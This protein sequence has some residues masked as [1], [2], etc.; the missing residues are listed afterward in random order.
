VSS[1]TFLDPFNA[2]SLSFREVA[3]TFVPSPKFS[4]L[5]GRWN[6][7]LIGPR[8]SGK[9]TLMKMLTVEALRTYEGPLAAS[10]RDI[11]TYTGIY[12]P[13]DIAWKEMV[14]ALCSPLDESVAMLVS[15]AAFLTNV[16]QS[17]V[18]AMQTR[19][20]VSDP[21]VSYP[22]FRKAQ[23][24][25]GKLEET[26]VDIAQLWHL[27][28][29]SIS[30]QGLANALA[31]RLSDI[32]Q[33]ANVFAMTERVSVQDVMK[34]MPY[35]GLSV[36]QAVSSAVQFFDQAINEPDGQWV[37]LLDE[38]E[39]A[40][41]QLQQSV[42]ASLRASPPKLL[43]K[44][45]LSPCGPH[46]MHRE[47]AATP[48]TLHND[49]RQVHLWYVDREHAEG[50]CAHIF[51]SLK[52]RWPDVMPNAS[53]EKVFG[54]TGYAIV[55]ETGESVE[56]GSYGRG[57]FWRR[58]FQQ[59]AQKDRT[60]SDFLIE[61][62]I[63]ADELDPS[64]SAPNGNTIRKIAPVVA[65]RNAYKGK[66]EGQKRGRRPFRSAYSGWAAICAISEGNPRWFI[67]LINSLAPCL[68]AT[69]TLPISVT[70]QQNKL[71]DLSE[72]FAEILRS[73]ATSQLRGLDTDA[74]VYDVLA[75]IGEYF[76]KRLVLDRFVEDP[77]MS[78][79]V[80]DDVDA[81]TEN[82]LRIAMNHGALVCYENPDS[83]GGYASLRGKRFR[84]AYLLAPA[85]K[86]PLRKSKAV[87][88][89]KALAMRETPRAP[90]QTGLLWE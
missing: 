87:N 44:V 43:F 21:S 64:P 35:A 17:V 33:R 39:V 42:L 36:V 48:P 65:F 32:Q 10:Y 86:L 13:A 82:A 8:G 70:E 77:P 63:D 90:V 23:S 20:Q 40:P 7:L 60:F 45:A 75:R 84:M 31:L 11:V 50:F 26:V 27:S 22:H 56:A 4:E 68:A 38:F 24:S 78:F 52:S 14:N 58:E 15:G 46:T 74:S 66:A 51:E 85:F 9:T 71:S 67:G 6:S 12:V 16:L 88:L 69:N 19:L 37:L 73:A 53:P 81:D 2:K 28:P 41:Q 72:A 59:L 55:D 34:A 83:L 1:T 49:Y 25:A 89:S 30:L 18:L 62:G 3:Q 5:S 47:T 61:K 57:A 54:S 79:I 29:R 76:H 80:D